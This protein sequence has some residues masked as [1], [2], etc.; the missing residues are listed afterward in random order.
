M[1]DLTLVA[2]IFYGITILAELASG[3]VRRIFHLEEE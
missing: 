2:L 1:L 3:L